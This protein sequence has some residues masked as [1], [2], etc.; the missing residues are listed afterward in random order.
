VG[1]SKNAYQHREHAAN[2]SILTGINSVPNTLRQHRFQ[3]GKCEN[4]GFGPAQISENNGDF[5]REYLCLVCSD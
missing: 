1:Y 2:F 3:L 5:L 4:G